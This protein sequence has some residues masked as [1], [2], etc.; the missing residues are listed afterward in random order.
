MKRVLCNT[1]LAL[2]GILVLSASGNAAASFH[3]KSVCYK[4]NIGS[5]EF[6]E[7]IRINVKRQ[8]QLT[9]FREAIRHKHPIQTVYSLDG[10]DI[11]IQGIEEPF[12]PVTSSVHGTITVAK[13]VGALMA[14]SWTGLMGPFPFHGRVSCSS[15]D[16]SATPDVWNECA[17]HASFLGG[18]PSSETQYLSLEKVDPL[19][20]PL[21]STF[22][23]P[24]PPTQR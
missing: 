2:A 12:Q 3:G 15:T 18:P 1:T 9:S 16:D 17:L 21:C 7:F 10:K 11:S 22:D 19:S 14:Y 23:L 4:F 5:P 6:L 8:G 24:Q 13:G 20:E